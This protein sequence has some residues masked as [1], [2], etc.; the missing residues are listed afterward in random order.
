VTLR[1][2]EE[3]KPHRIADHAQPQ[4]VPHDRE[5]NMGLRAAYLAW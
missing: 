2:K 1:Q 5:A 3:A 4:D